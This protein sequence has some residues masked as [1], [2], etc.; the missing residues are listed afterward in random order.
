MANEQLV[1]SFY[2]ALNK[3]KLDEILLFFADD[4][5]F[6]DMS[7]GRVF[8]GKNEI[9]KFCETWLKGFSD[10]KLHPKKVI[11]E[12]NAFSAEI[13]VQGTH[14]GNFESPF[15][16]LPAS[17]KKIDV[18]SCDVYEV[19]DNKIRS[20]HCYFAAPVFFSQIGASPVNLKQ[21]KAA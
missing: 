14:D 7:S 9:G 1:R 10:F 20:M 19:A 5:Q 13:S 21:Q 2:E 3:H 12:G 15:G 18:P 16:T 11:G 17:N 4:A 8:K 6:F